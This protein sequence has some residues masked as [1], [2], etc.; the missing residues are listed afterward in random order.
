MDF[1]K[2]EKTFKVVGIK[3][4]GSFENYSIEVPELARQFLSRI[5]EIDSSNGNEIALFEP[6]IDEDHLEGNYYVGVIVDK[7]FSAVPEG[8]EY[9]ELSQS[10]VSARGPITEIGTLYHNLL[11]WSIKQQYK[12]NIESYI[13]EIYHPM[14]NGEEVEIYLPIR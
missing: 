5:N 14:D 1:K 3:G 12:R 10:Y 7:S 8:M 13:I 9:I 11:Q 2:V 4:K 6:K